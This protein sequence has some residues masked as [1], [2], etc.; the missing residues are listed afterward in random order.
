MVLDSYSLIPNVRKVISKVYEED[1]SPKTGT[2]SEIY[3][4]TAKNIFHSYLTT[5][6]RDLRLS[7]Q[8]EAE[9]FEKEAKTPSIETACRT[10]T[11]QCLEGAYN[12]GNLLNAIFSIDPL[13]STST[14]SAFHAL[15]SGQRWL[16]TPANLKPLATSVQAAFQT[17]ELRILCNYVSWLTHEYLTSDYY[18][19]ESPFTTKCRQYTASLLSDYLWAFVDSRFEAETTASIAKAEVPATTENAHQVLK[20][21]I[22]LLAM[23]DQC[24]P[25]ERCVSSGRW[26]SKPVGTNLLTNISNSNKTVQLFSR[27]FAKPSMC[28]SVSKQ[29]SRA[30][31]QGSMLTCS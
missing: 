30:A 7:A 22:E 25:K 21:A 12:E 18:E 29:R 9:A 13:P 15:R 16:I 27:L 17:T 31:R 26:F 19:D 8:R 20:V 4:N 11:K 5:R 23:F 1:G 2:A 6:D 10:Y 24:M 28:C 14:E 3:L